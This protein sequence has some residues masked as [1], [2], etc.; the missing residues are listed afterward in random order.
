MRLTGRPE[1]LKLARMAG[2]RVGDGVRALAA[3]LEAAAWSN[4]A[5]VRNAF[6][7]SDLSGR[8]LTV[9]FDGDH[10]AVIAI[11]YEKGVALVEYA[12]SSAGRAKLRAKKSDGR[13]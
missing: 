3:E 11:S 5:D 2:G 9:S 12:G 13:A 7:S 10:C 8:R 1:L 6:P 4:N